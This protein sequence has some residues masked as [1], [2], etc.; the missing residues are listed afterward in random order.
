MNEQ[1]TPGCVLRMCVEVEVLKAIFSLLRHSVTPVP[2][3]AAAL[4][5]TFIYDKEITPLAKSHVICLP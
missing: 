2:S 4:I 5:Y 1:V 3:A